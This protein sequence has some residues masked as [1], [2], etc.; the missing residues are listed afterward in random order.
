M[1]TVTGGTLMSHKAG[2]FIFF[3]NS[4]VTTVSIKTQVL[5]KGV[6]F[7]YVTGNTTWLLILQK[8]AAYIS[9]N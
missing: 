7:L 1:N 2:R 3:L 8:S 6:R 4:Y 5:N 9:P